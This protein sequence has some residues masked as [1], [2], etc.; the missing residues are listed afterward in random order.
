MNKA[1]AHAKKVLEGV[2]LTGFAI[3]IGLG[4]AYLC[5]SFSSFQEF[6]DSYLLIEASKNLCFDEYTGILYPLF[7]LCM[8]GFTYVIPVPLFIPV[9]IF[10]LLAAFF[11]GIF[12][13][14]T[15][16]KRHWI[17]NVYGSLCIMTMPFIMQCH[18]ALLPQSLA[19]TLLLLEL[20]FFIRFV[21][22]DKEKM[23]NLAAVGCCMLLLTLLMPEYLL[24]ASVFVIVGTGYLFA[25]KINQKFRPALCVILLVCLVL[26]FVSV[27][28]ERQE[29]GTMREKRSLAAMTL[30]RF[31]GSRFEET[32]GYWP[33]D[34]R[35]CISEETVIWCGEHALDRQQL[36]VQQAVSALGSERAEQ[37]FFEAAKFGFQVYGKEVR[38]EILIDMATY[39]FSPFLLQ[40][41][42]QGRGPISF[43]GRNY[44][45]LRTC[46]PRL[47]AYYINYAG[48]W[49]AMGILLSVLCG[50]MDFVIILNGK[51]KGQIMEKRNV[52]EVV[53]CL[54]TG[55]LTGMLM[56]VCYTFQGSGIMDYKNTIFLLVVYWMF[57][58]SCMDFFYPSLTDQSKDCEPE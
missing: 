35:T 20:S 9:K 32:Y 14:Q 7:L 6:G 56:V 15:I 28:Y 39:T 2:L 40:Y 27:I 23:G 46:C 52:R 29:H 43:S 13:M 5:V 51:R 22:Q 34:L 25:K 50:L 4:L 53:T 42:L 17:K 16:Y 54:W 18:T 11:S 57:Q 41:Q 58:S 30:S 21:R 10:Q 12:L 47:S 33:E 31:T 49:F 36:L 26:S 37:A 45:I 38:H 19:L 8:R 55:F 44:D 1:L 24:F 3:Q 48:W